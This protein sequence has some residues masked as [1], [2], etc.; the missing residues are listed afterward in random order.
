MAEAAE[1]AHVVIVR[2][3]CEAHKKDIDTS[4]E[5]STR[6]T[7]EQIKFMRQ[8][9]V[10]LRDY[11]LKYAVEIYGHLDPEEYME[12]AHEC[13]IPFSILTKSHR[14]YVVT[15]Q[16]DASKSN[17]GE[18][19]QKS[20]CNDVCFCEHVTRKCVRHKDG[21]LETERMLIKFQDACVEPSVISVDEPIEWWDPFLE[22]LTVHFKK[23]Y[24]PEVPAF[25]TR[26][27]RLLLAYKE[28]PGAIATLQKDM[29]E[30]YDDVIDSGNIVGTVFDAFKMAKEKRWMKGSAIIN[31][32]LTKGIWMRVLKSMSIFI[33]RAVWEDH[34]FE[35]KLIRDFYAKYHS[36]EPGAIIS[37]AAKAEMEK[38]HALRV[39]GGKSRGRSGAASGASTH[40]NSEYYN[41]L[42][43]FDD[44]FR[45]P[46]H[47][48]LPFDE[49]N[50][51]QPFIS[52][53]YNDVSG[54]E[55][56]L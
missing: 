15:T 36:I 41:E 27:R 37:K 6:P 29:D 42:D 46:Q 10:G 22:I 4:K 50:H 44:S 53:E 26:L 40:A 19:C 9:L 43:V 1:P 28:E 32:G 5:S 45:Y 7:P 30:A 25:L 2:G 54:S 21:D 34:E 39:I 12:L 47:S 3:K 33:T 51:H 52:D 23:E 55:S 31:P 8:K 16:G 48:H 56:S 14:T 20:L 18:S 38:A 17:E 24:S 11:W 13:G 35:S 49:R